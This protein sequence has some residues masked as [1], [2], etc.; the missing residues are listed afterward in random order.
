MPLNKM[1]LVPFERYKRM[2]T[3]R[4]AD[5]LPYSLEDIGNVSEA[6]QHGAGKEESKHI[7]SGKTQTQVLSS[8]TAG[9]KQFTPP[10]PPTSPP[11]P[12][13]PPP[14]GAPDISSSFSEE[15]DKEQVTA[16]NSWLDK[17][18]PLQPLNN[19]RAKGKSQH[20]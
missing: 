14:P 12:P 17:W 16:E 8:P 9:K 5:H 1:V 20:K 4:S 10:L 7:K 6:S 13:P 2:A 15:F 3:D 18:E 11:P 19:G